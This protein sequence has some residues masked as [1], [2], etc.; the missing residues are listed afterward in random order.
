M[1]LFKRDNVEKISCPWH[2]ERTP[3]CHVD[4]SQDIVFCFGCQKR[5]TI[6]EAVEQSIEAFR[7]REYDY[8]QLLDYVF[9][10]ADAAIAR[11]KVETERQ[12]RILMAVKRSL[13][14]IR[15]SA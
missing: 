2:I 9:A 14:A 3:S 4:F 7:D 15:A 6:E 10:R 13:D 1:K 5:A 11:A 8:E 12:H